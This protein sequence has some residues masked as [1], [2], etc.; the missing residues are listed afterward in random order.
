MKIAV[1]MDEILCEYFETYL[2]FYNKKFNTHFKIEDI[3]DYNIW[4]ILGGTYEDT[5]ENTAL[6]HDSDIFKTIPVIEGAIKGI[7]KIKKKHQL[8]LVTG[9]P[10]NTKKMTQ[11][12]LNQ[13]FPECFESV[14]FANHWSKSGEQLKKSTFCKQLGAELLIDDCLEYAQDCGNNGIKVLLMDR[15]WNQVESL[16]ENII[17]VNSWDE[18]VKKLG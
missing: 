12:W 1:D 16:S 5:V 14:N 9:R 13:Y 10:S 7:K 11:I 6:Y 8:V 15:P 4:N 3:T 2:K 17:R 18:I